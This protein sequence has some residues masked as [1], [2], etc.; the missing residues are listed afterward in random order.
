MRSAPRTTTRSPSA[1]PARTIEAGRVQRLG[2]DRARLEPFR[3]DVAPDHG[4][5][6]AGAD[7]GVARQDDAG[8]AGPGPGQDGHRLADA[9][10]RGRID[11]GELHHRRLLLE[12]AAHAL[13]DE[14]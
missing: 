2:P 1:T 10:V 6:V 12:G 5:A 3:I 14:L 13:G 11:D 4:L 8:G 7:H 9:Q